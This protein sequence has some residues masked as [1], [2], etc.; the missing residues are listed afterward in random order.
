MLQV[1][2]CNVTQVLTR[3]KMHITNQIKMLQIIT[4]LLTNQYDCK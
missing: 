3:F 2:K 4:I 1:E